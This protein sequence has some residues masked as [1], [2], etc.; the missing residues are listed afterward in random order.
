[1][2]RCTE[3]SAR[4][5]AAHWYGMSCGDGWTSWCIAENGSVQRFYDAY[6]CEEDQGPRHP[7]E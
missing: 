4:F 6:A 1:L 2:E 3:L 7:A 5:G